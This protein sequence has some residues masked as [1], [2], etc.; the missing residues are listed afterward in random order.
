MTSSTAP[1]AGTIIEIS[2][3]TSSEMII[4]GIDDTIPCQTILPTWARLM[5]PFLSRLKIALPKPTT[6][7][8]F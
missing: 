2:F 7:S 5:P 4:P 3:S 6:S 1:A 8:T